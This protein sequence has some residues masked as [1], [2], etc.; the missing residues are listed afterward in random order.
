MRLRNKPWASDKLREHPQYVVWEDDNVKGNWQKHF[1]QN[2]PIHL[3]VGSGKG[4]FMI[5]MAKAHPDINYIAMEL[6]TSVVI[7]I[8]EAQIEEDLPNLMILHGHGG[9]LDEYFEKAEVSQVYLNFSDPWPKTRHEK[10]R[11]TSPKFLTQYENIF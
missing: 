11:L 8:L 1:Q 3:E 4:R 5:E 2:Q 10:R 7:S 9:D 6:Q